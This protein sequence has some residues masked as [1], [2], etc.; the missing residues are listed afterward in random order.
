MAPAVST[1]NVIP[2]SPG[3][4]WWKNTGK[5]DKKDEPVEK[6]I[7]WICVGYPS[8]EG[9]H[10][11]GIVE[12]VNEMGLKACVVGVCDTIQRHTLSLL[13]RGTDEAQY[14]LAFDN[15]T[16]WIVR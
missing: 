10:M 13:D 9:E 11:A 4:V 14:E 15:G 5:K 12:D 2:E 7:I 1:A 8:F 16:A 3:K 6:C